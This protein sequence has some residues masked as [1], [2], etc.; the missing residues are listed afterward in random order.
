[1]PSAASSALAAVSIALGSCAGLFGAFSQTDDTQVCADAFRHA[2]DCA[3]TLDSPFLTDPTCQGSTQCAAA[4]F[5]NAPCDALFDFANHLSDD[6][7]F[8][9]LDACITDCLR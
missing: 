3:V 7:G 9:D 2:S 4:C 5:A 6:T 1:M 8:V